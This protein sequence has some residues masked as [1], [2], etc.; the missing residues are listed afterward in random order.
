MNQSDPPALPSVL[1]RLLTTA[2]A[3][4]VRLEAELAEIGLSLPK[5]KVLRIL[6]QEDGPQALSRLAERGQCVKSNITQLID[7][8]EAEGLVRRSED[9]SDGRIRL[10]S[11]TAQGQ[12]ACR[13]AMAIIETHEQII[14]EALSERDA[15]TLTRVLDRL[16]DQSG[17]PE[18]RTAPS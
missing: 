15:A 13:R 9:P 6:S 4:E 8:L 14:A 18:G 3:V 17:V 5:A 11:L 7:R 12:K 2:R 10:A 16:H 1:G